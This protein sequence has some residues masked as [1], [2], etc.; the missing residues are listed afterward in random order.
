MALAVAESAPAGSAAVELL[1]AA[2]LRQDGGTQYRVAVDP[3][4][5]GR[6]RELIADAD[7][8]PDGRRPWPFRDAVEAVQGATTADLWLVDGFQRLAAWGLYFGDSSL[9][10][11]PPVP[12]RIVAV[13]DG[14]GRRAALLTAAGSNAAHGAPRSDADKRNAV[15]HLLSDPEWAAWSDREIARRCGVSAPFVGNRRQALA[16]KAAGAAVVGSLG[17][18]PAVRKYTDR[19]GVERTMDTDKI[20]RKAAAEFGRAVKSATWGDNVRGRAEQAAGALASGKLGGGS[21]VQSSAPSSRVQSPDLGRCRVCNRPLSDPASAAA[22]VGPCCAGKQAAGGA[23]AA[24]VDAGGAADG[25]GA[26]HGHLVALVDAL[27]LL[28][29]EMSDPAS[30]ALWAKLQ[31]AIVPAVERVGAFL[32]AGE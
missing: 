21:V 15:D 30:I 18:V 25:L 20:G 6:Y 19:Q 24:A 32:V 27:P 16:A 17:A 14:D 7:P 2:L 10:S 31:A 13:G 22:G 12:V 3:L 11:V 8:T 23:A 26:V 1:P 29:R 9:V 28:R 5:V 4:V